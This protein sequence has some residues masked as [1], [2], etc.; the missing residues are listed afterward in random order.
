MALVAAARAERR[1]R[2]VLTEIGLRRRGDPPF[3]QVAQV[4]LPQARLQAEQ[5][6]AE[7]VSEQLDRHLGRG[8]AE[9]KRLA[10]APLSQQCEALAWALAQER[11]REDLMA[12]AARETSR[13]ELDAVTSKLGQPVSHVE[14]PAR[15]DADL[16]VLGEHSTPVPAAAYFTERGESPF[17][18][19]Q[20]CA[21]PTRPVTMPAGTPPSDPA[22]LATFLF[23]RILYSNQVCDRNGQAVGL[24]PAMRADYLAKITHAIEQGKPIV[25]SEYAPL[26]AI[27]NPIKRNT[28]TPSL[29]EIDMLRRL[30]ETAHAVEL[31]YPPGMHWLLGNEATVFQGPHFGLPEVYVGQFHEQCQDLARLI[32]PEGRRLTVFDQADLNWGCGCRLFI[33]AGQAACRYSWRVPPSRS[34]LR[35][36]SCA[37]RSGSAIGSGSGRRGAAARRVRWGRCSL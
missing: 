1:K 4:F 25:A 21:L 14:R 11:A 26:V 8:D 36:S 15:N 17:T 24:S 29:T 31:Y 30:S 32:D 28:Q 12:I 13:D 22:G 6:S 34:R 5:E 37:I 33:R 27:S 9:R 23:D 19:E 35:T 18:I 3:D 20:W 16:R 2:Q 7:A 10:A